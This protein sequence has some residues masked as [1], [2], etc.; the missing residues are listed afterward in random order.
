MSTNCT[1]EVAVDAADVG[2][3][4]TVAAPAV[5][6]AAVRTVVASTA[7]ETVP[8]AARRVVREGVIFSPDLDANRPDA[9]R[10]QEGRRRLDVNGE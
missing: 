6:G 5:V 4:A 2:A 10:R 9:V 7:A 1:E 3:E 8:I